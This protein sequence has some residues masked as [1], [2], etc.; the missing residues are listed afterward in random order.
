MRVSIF[1][2]IFAVLGDK[3][4]HVI[5]LLGLTIDVDSKIR[6]LGLDIHT[7]SILE[8]TF[9]LEFPSL[10]DVKHWVFSFRQVSLDDTEG[11]VPFVGTNIHLES[12]NKLTCVDEVL[13][14]QIKLTNL[15]V[16]MCDLFVIWTSDFWWLVG[17]QL[18]CSVPF[19]CL[20]SCTDGLVE[21]TSLDI[22]LDRKIKLLLAD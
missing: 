6:F 4:D 16:V 20:Q 10:I 5:V 21:V 22:M 9:S 7:F 15:N 1:E 13:L 18:Y 2:E 12:L 14:S 17:N 11:L 8:V 3:T 19:T